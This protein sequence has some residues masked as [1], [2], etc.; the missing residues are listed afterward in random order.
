VFSFII[1]KP[2]VPTNYKQTKQKDI[3]KILKKAHI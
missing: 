2:N 3:T 1:T